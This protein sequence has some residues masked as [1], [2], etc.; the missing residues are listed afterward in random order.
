MFTRNIGDFDED[1]N[2]DRALDEPISQE[3]ELRLETYT[4]GMHSKIIAPALQM[5]HDGN[6]ENA[7]SFLRAKIRHVLRHPGWTR[8]LFF[9]VLKDSTRGLDDNIRRDIFKIIAGI[10]AE[11]RPRETKPSFHVWIQTLTCNN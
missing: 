3:K 9:N 11:A 4:L 1:E 10:Y 2:I 7:K 6:T 8:K 5:I